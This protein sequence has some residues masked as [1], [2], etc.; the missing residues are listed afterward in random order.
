MTSS[1]G[2]TATTITRS[3]VSGQFHSPASSRK[4]ADGKS[5]QRR[6]D[7]GLLW[8]GR[9]RFG[10]P[11]GGLDGGATHRRT[12][13][14]VLCTDISLAGQSG[15][16]NTKL[17]DFRTSAATSRWSELSPTPLN[18]ASVAVRDAELGSLPA[19]AARAH[20]SASD[21]RGCQIEHLRPC[22]CRS[23]PGHGG[24]RLTR[25][26]DRRARCGGQRGLP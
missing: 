22:G 7:P 25:Y 1:L 20:P 3:G 5:R 26:H 12:R 17:G 2:R 23:S 4:A 10:T 15:P 18:R 8:T 24:C 21:R 14:R 6:N 19:G 13:A 16:R 11:C 9:G